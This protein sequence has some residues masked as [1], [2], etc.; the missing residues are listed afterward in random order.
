MVAEIAGEEMAKTIQ[1]AMEYSPKPPFSSGTP[2][3]AS[4]ETVQSVL[5]G[6]S[7]IAG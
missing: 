5:D 3:E 1:L 4:P 7:E 6:Y 2:E